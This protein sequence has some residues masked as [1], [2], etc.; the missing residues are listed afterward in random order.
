[1][2]AKNYG[3]K[4]LSPLTHPLLGGVII[5]LWSL[6]SLC[7]APASPKSVPST[8]TPARKDANG[9]GINAKANSSAIGVQGNSN[10]TT[11]VNNKT[12]VVY[13]TVVVNH[14]LGKTLPSKS[15]PKR[16]PKPTS[17]DKKSPKQQQ[18]SNPVPVDKKS[19][20]TTATP[21]KNTNCLASH[22]STYC[23]TT[24]KLLK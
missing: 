5:L 19:P 22:S 13:K 11:V 20:T 3:H 6:S 23:N 15:I 17:A 21:P 16:T 9:S 4:Y 7:A 1:M 14:Y 24:G 8:T 18:I 2:Y 10:I 12:V